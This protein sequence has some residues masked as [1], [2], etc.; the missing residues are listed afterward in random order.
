MEF[1]INGITHEYTS[2]FPIGWKMKS[3]DYFKYPVKIG[4]QNFF[5]KRFERDPLAIDLLKRLKDGVPLPNMP[6][7]YAFQGSKEEKSHYLF[8]EYIHGVELG[9]KMEGILTFDLKDY[10]KQL[11]HAFEFIHLQGFWH[12]DFTEEN[13]L[14]DEYKKFYLIDIDSCRPLSTPASVDT[15]KD[16]SFSGSVFANLKRINPLFEF[17]DLDGRQI[18][19]LQLLFSIIHFYNFTYNRGKEIYAN[20]RK[21]TT[22]NNLAKL[23]P[24]ID[25]IFSKA[26]EERL[27]FN[28]IEEVL[29]HL[30]LRGTTSVLTNQ[31]VDPGFEKVS[32]VVSNINPKDNENDNISPVPQLPVSFDKKEELKKP[33]IQSF[34]VNGQTKKGITVEYGTKYLLSWIVL[35]ATH[36]ELDGSQLPV[37]PQRRYLQA[38]QT[39]VHQFIAIN[40][41]GNSEKKSDPITLPVKVNQQARKP[42][43]VQNQ[44]TLIYFKVNEK[45]SNFNVHPN[46]KVTISWH[47]ENVDFVVVNNEQ[48]LPKHH[49]SKILDKPETF[50]IE[51]EG[52]IS[53]TIQ[54][55]FYEPQP[56]PPPEVHSFLV[57]S[58]DQ[59][60]VNVESKANLH[61]T[62]DTTYAQKMILYKDGMILPLPG[63][64]AEKDEYLLKEENRTRKPKTIELKFVAI[65][66]ENQQTEVIRYICL[67]PKKDQRLLI[68]LLVLVV[69][70]LIVLL[71]FLFTQLNS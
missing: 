53:R 37:T 25:Q 38:D 47:V 40:K 22:S 3:H 28:D 39:K 63:K 42:K 35:N 45:T 69:L 16:A 11:F 17:G 54:V 10:A 56:T 65:S 27:G 23:V 21:N 15:I 32:E 34:E 43:E 66:Q 49:F 67:S 46:T 64:K 51:A 61:I 57:N 14:I 52:I 2:D 58:T 1:T 18:N 55:E 48:N 36:V 68:G 7:I 71:F 30:S 20:F 70:V 50:T 59:K 60:H 29:N 13:I 41:I 4:D 8:Q 44:P 31:P 5:I 12:T 33:I 26:F 6:K 62:W 9:Q 24:F 19:I